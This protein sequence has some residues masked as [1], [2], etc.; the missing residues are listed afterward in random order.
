[1]N[2]EIQLAINFVAEVV[3]IQ[4][5][6]KYKEHN[7]VIRLEYS[8]QLQQDQFHHITHLCAFVFPQQSVSSLNDTTVTDLRPLHGSLIHVTQDS[9]KCSPPKT[10]RPF[11]CHALL[12]VVVVAISGPL[13]HIMW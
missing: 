1:M 6:Q 9:T 2:D 4:N 13:L 7:A 11:I 5:T 12:N 10:K 3:I 8:L